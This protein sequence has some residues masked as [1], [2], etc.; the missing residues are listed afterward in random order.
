MQKDRKRYNTIIMFLTKDKSHEL[1]ISLNDLITC[2]LF[3]NF[4]MLS[5]ISYF[6]NVSGFLENVKINNDILFIFLSIG[7]TAVT[8]TVPVVVVISVILSWLLP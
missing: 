6:F 2:L 8:S 4:T 1:G 3:I 7:A 5:R